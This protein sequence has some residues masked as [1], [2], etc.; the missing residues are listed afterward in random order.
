MDMVSQKNQLNIEAEHF[1]KPF[2]GVIFKKFIQSVN[3]EEINSLRRLYSGHHLD[4]L[5]STSHEDLEILD[6]R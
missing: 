3:G 5:T 4:F 6:T 1:K 2:F